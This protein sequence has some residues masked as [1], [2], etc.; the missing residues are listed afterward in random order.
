VSLAVAEL[1]SAAGMIGA[2]LIAFETLV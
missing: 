1:G 2:G